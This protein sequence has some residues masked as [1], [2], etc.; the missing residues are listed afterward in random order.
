MSRAT[1]ADFL[2]AA[3]GTGVEVEFESLPHGQHIHAHAPKGML[4]D[5]TETHNI[6]AWDGSGRIDYDYALRQ[7]AMIPC[8]IEDCDACSEEEA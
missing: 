5:E 2:A 1:K 8:T 7:I 6:C 3:S 4:F